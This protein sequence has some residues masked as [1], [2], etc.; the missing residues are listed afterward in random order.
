MLDSIAQFFIQGGIFMV[1]LMLLS[2][3]ALTVIVWRALALRMK[4]VLP[5]AIE[6]EVADLEPGGSLDGLNAVL[7]SN[8]SPLARVLRALAEHIH[9]SRDEAVEAIQTRARHEVMR[10][11][12]GLVF[13][14][15]ATGVGPILGLLGTLSG[16]VT[17]FTSIG[18][19]P[20]LVAR[21][22][23]EALNTTIV[24]L[25]VAAPSLIAYNYF[26]RK[27]EIMAITM[28]TLSAEILAKRLP[29]SD[30]QP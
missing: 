17:I 19:D 2:L 5:P 22:I 24:G 20:V 29:P 4:T 1:F 21:G 11:E 28:E 16:L 27:V 23:A 3:V 30:H 13:L 12:T 15:I 8:P 6:A 25:G 18:N 9:W 14:E 10:L 26:S 7:A